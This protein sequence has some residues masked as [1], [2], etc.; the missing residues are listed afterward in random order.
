M[1]EPPLSVLMTTDAVGGVWR[2]SLD[3]CRE[4]SR[5]GSTT[6]LVC[7][8]P[9]P[10]E[11]QR[12]EARL[13]PQLTFLE[14]EESLEWMPDP[15][16]GVE[17]SGRYLLALAA[18]LQPD[19]VH[20]NGYCHGVLQFAAPKVVVGHSCVLSWWRAVEQGPVPAELAAYRQRVTLGLQ[21]AQAVIAPS[22]TMLRCLKQHYG[23]KAGRVIFNGS[24]RSR[25]PSASGVPKEP[26]VLCAARLWDRAK[27]VGTLADAARGCIWP[28]MVAGA[29]EAPSSVMALGHLGSEALARWMQR[30]SIYALPARYEPFGLSVLEAAAAG[31]ALVLGDIAS[32][33][34]L[35]AD[36]ALYVSPDDA[37]ALRSA[38]NRLAEDSRLRTLLGERAKQRALRYTLEEQARRYRRVY[39]ELRAQ[40]G[41]H[42]VASRLVSAGRSN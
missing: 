27:N 16:A 21:G 22:E 38:L 15:W 40:T 1:L 35:W 29:G 19:V 26:L 8:G 23:L 4:L 13:V 20:L 6:T 33:R 5:D 18:E 17:Q 24:P 9:A 2:Y 7:L 25:F 11:E 10:S 12:A 14:Y 31:A 41:N 39:R 3:L 32:L 37:G 28:V 34:E 42:R 30:A 36:A